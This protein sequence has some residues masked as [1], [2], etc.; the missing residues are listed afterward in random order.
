MWAFRKHVRSFPFI[1]SLKKYIFDFVATWRLCFGAWWCVPIRLC[2]FFALSCVQCSSF[3]QKCALFCYS[4]VC[5]LDWITRLVLGRYSHVC[6]YNMCVYSCIELEWAYLHM[7]VLCRS[8][9]CATCSVH[10]HS[11]F[12][13]GWRAFAKIWKMHEHVKRY[14]IYALRHYWYEKYVAQRTKKH[15][16]VVDVHVCAWVHAF[17]WIYVHNLVMQCFFMCFSTMFTPRFRLTC[18]VFFH[19]HPQL[20]RKCM[21]NHCFTPK[22]Y[23]ARNAAIEYIDRT[24]RSFPAIYYQNVIVINTALEVRCA[25]FSLIFFAAEMSY[26]TEKKIFAMLLARHQLLPSGKIVRNMT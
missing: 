18:T 7:H 12:H 19:V 20:A 17:D 8:V 22:P 24:H 10:V 25:L 2:H 4:R 5:L 1:S 14:A 6:M 15:V 16:F 26:R 23:S 3:S 21:K 13:T 11:H 9:I